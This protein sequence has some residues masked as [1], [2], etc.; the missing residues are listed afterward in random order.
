MAFYRMSK[1]SYTEIVHIISPA[2]YQNNTNMRECVRAEEQ[3]VYTLKYVCDVNYY[4]FN[5]NF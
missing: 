4:T 2:I 3:I 1:E 5:N